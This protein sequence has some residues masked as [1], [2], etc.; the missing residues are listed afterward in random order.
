MD[1]IELLWK[2]L[3]TSA[4]FLPKPYQEYTITERMDNFCEARDNG[5][6]LMEESWFAAVLLNYRLMIVKLCKQHAKTLK[7][8][9]AD[10][11]DWFQC[12][13]LQAADN[14]SWQQ[15]EKNFNAGTVIT[16]I[17]N[18]RFLAAA[19]YESNLD[20]NKANFATIS[21]DAPLDSDTDDTR[22]DLLE[23][24]FAAPVD[25]YGKAAGIIQ[26]LINENKI[27]EA[28]ITETIAYHDCLKVNS[29]MVKEVGEDGTIKRYKDVSSSFWPYRVVQILSNLPENYEDYFT[30]KFTVDK[31]KFK[32]GLHKIRTSSN[33]KLYKFL[34]S[35]QDYLRA[36]L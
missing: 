28:I 16:Q 7:L 36:T 1:T 9:M 24:N 29:K 10:F 22:L 20:I 13:I 27:I 23:S 21:L 2:N 14:R 19:Y 30:N 11:I 26:D 5:D 17:V 32:V 18:T 31:T 33:P 6:S 8:E 15:D 34:E 4:S 3:E 12:A 35:T 25:Q